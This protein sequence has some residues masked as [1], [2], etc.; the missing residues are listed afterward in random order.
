MSVPDP[1]R[2]LPSLDWNKLKKDWPYLRK[3][4]FPKLSEFP[5]VNMIIGIELT[6]FHYSIGCKIIPSSKPF[7]RKMP[8]GWI[9]MEKMYLQL[10]QEQQILTD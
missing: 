5:R 3:V 10:T 6:M 4:K 9:A 7:A 8:M 2:D 1:V